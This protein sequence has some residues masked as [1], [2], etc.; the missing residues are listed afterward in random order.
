MINKPS[1]LAAKIIIPDADRAQKFLENKKN[2]NFEECCHDCSLEHCKCNKCDSPLE[3]YERSEKHTYLK[4][5]NMKCD[6]D[7]FMCGDVTIK[8]IHI[9]KGS[10]P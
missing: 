4:C 3:R 2:K 6:F 7:E 5:T 1:E 8:K 9:P 10:K